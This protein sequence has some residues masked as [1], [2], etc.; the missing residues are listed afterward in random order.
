MTIN[1]A[2]EV[3]AEDF[4]GDS[5]G[6]CLPPLFSKRWKQRWVLVLG[7]RSLLLPTE[8]LIKMTDLWKFT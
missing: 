3:I 7:V 1:L 4:S 5:K 8:D 6:K 2:A